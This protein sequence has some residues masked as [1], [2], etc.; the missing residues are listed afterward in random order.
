MH[1][2][3]GTK[4]FS[5]NLECQCRLLEMGISGFYLGQKLAQE[6]YMSLLLILIFFEQCCIY[7]DFSNNQVKIECVTG[8]KA[9]KNQW[10]GEILFDCCKSLVT[11]LIPASPLGA[12]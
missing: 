10:F 1:L 11:L 12:F 8:F 5:S 7:R 6:E 3:V 2:E 9:N 4:N